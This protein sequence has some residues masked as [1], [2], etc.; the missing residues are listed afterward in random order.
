MR[1]PLAEAL[2]AFEARQ[3]ESDL[4]QYRFEQLLYVIGGGRRRPR[5]PRSLEKRMSTG[6]NGTS[7]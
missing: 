4:E 1:W 6:S 5:P 7:W 2:L 3:Q